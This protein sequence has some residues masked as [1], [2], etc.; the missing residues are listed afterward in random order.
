MLEF[1]FGETIMQLDF[2]EGWNDCTTF[3]CTDGRVEIARLLV[4]S[5]ADLNIKDTWY[6]QTALHWSAWHHRVEIARL[7]VES[8]AHL[9]IQ[10]TRHGNTALHMAFSEENISVAKVLINGGSNLYAVNSDADTPL[11][12]FFKTLRIQCVK[13]ADLTVFSETLSRQSEEL[14]I[15][16]VQLK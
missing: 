11:E 15:H 9:D 6:G 10:D 8:K 13:D 5:K 12:L 7:L 3:E 4:E 16:L 1:V 14:G 2:V